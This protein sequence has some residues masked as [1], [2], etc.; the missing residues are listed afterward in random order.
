MNHL[1]QSGPPGGIVRVALPVPLPQ[2]FDYLPGEFAP[3][4]GCR[5]LVPFGR[6][7]RI[8]IVVEYGQSAEVADDR[9]KPITAVL[10]EPP[11]LDPELLADLRRA[12]DYW[13]GAIGDVLFGAL[14][15]ALRRGRSPSDF[16]EEAWRTTPAGIAARDADTR[17]GGSAALLATLGDA[18]LAASELETLLPGW[19]AAA[20]RLAAAGLV[21]CAEPDRAPPRAREGAAPILTDD[22]ADALA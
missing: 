11:L 15:L 14:P 6:G 4:P 17:R 10:D 9:L 1:R 7:R 13:C 18:I 21:E 5:V 19:R 16:A 22:Q 20:R 8:G 12:A 3:Q 2:T